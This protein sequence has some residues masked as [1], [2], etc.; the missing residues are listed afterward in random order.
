MRLEE[1][2]KLQIVFKSNLS[3]KSRRRNKLEE[4]KI[5]LKKLNCFTNHNKLLLTYLMINLQLYLRPNTKFIEKEFQ[6]C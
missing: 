3:K 6:V 5:T 4:H 2:K 1:A